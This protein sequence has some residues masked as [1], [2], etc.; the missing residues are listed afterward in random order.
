M[1]KTQCSPGGT[2]GLGLALV[3]N[4]IQE[5]QGHPPASP[6]QSIRPCPLLGTFSPP[7]PTEKNQAGASFISR[8]LCH[9]HILKNAFSPDETSPHG[10]KTSPCG[11]KPLAETR[12]STRNFQGIRLAGPKDKD[13]GRT[14]RHGAEAGPPSAEPAWLL[15]AA[16]Q[17]R[18]I[19]CAR[20]TR[21]AGAGPLEPD[22]Q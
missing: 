19:P 5:R 15:A 21:G 11:E 12:V 6:L 2:L 7:K 1:A 3:V 8:T 22:E 10:E 17:P 4:K 13:K 9:V 14:G 20:G 16:S 18:C